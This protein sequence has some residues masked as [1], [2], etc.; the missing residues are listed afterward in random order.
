[1]KKKILFWSLYHLGMLIFSLIAAMVM[2]YNQTGN[3]FVP[4]TILTFAIIFTNCVL[5]GYLAIYFLNWGSRLSYSALNKKIIPAFIL[6]LVAALIIANLVVSAGAFVWYSVKG[7]ELQ[8]FVSNLIKNDLS[9]ANR[10]LFSWFLVFSIVFFY[11]L[12]KNA[13][14][15][16]SRLREENLKYKYKTL[17]SQVNPH[18][19]FNSLNTL[20]ELVYEDAK[21]ADSYIQKLSSIYRYVLEN[22]DIELVPLKNE[23]DFV[24][25]YF[26]L[27]KERDKDKIALTV[28]IDNMEDCK[29]VPVSLQLLVENAIKHNSISLDKPLKIN[30]KRQNDY[31][32]VSNNIQRKSI[33]EPTTKTG[34]QNLKERVNLI[35]R[36]ELIA[37]EKDNEFV[38]KLPIQLLK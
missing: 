15:K 11:I 7:W 26:D 30:I 22:E 13:S 36:K 34:L 29:I 12:W 28:D 6:F 35:M 33:I 27:Q 18:F 3:A 38:V 14:Q 17:K 1:M 2:K 8:G 20:S 37:E 24:R 31:L 10:S 32:I 23:I 19:L 4:E 25:H 5:T 21:Q 16:E 9:Y